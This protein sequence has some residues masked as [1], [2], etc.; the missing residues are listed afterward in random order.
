MKF[1][2]N[3]VFHNSHVFLKTVFFFI[4]TESYFV[5][6]FFVD[7]N[8]EKISFPVVSKKPITK[9]LTFLT[10]I[11]KLTKALHI[12]AYLGIRPDA[13]LVTL[14]SGLPKKLIQYF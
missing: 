8:L 10:L 13:I 7:H 11:A 2:K 6:A 14:I 3:S 4:N 5:R 12:V 9:N 1:T